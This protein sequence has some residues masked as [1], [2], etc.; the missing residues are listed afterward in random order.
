MKQCPKC[1]Q[2][3]A[4]PNLNFCLNDGELLTQSADTSIRSTF[5]NK[6]P[7]GY[8]DDDAPPTVMMNDPRATNP[9]GW[10][11]SSSPVPWQAQTPVYQ[12]PQQL[13]TQNYGSSQDQTLPIVSLVLGVLSLLFI[14]CYGGIW[15]GIPAAV[16][17]YFGMRNADADPT[18]YG[19]RGLAIGGMVVGAITFLAA[20]AFI[21][22]QII[23]QIV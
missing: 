11:G 4:D 15:L 21:I 22:L 14:C 19:G 18:R 17:G 9:A 1:G 13:G 16:V 3:F 8:A 5:G 20:I 10:Q 23:G 7:T 12:S 2:S 6:A